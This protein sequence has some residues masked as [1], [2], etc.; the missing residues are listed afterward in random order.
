MVPTLFLSLI[1]K[2]VHKTTFFLQNDYFVNLWENLMTMFVRRKG[3]GETFE[4]LRQLKE[5]EIFRT[6]ME[7]GSF[8]T[9]VL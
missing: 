6:R 1:V 2:N 3:K 8:V 7:K 9:E 4:R 5:G